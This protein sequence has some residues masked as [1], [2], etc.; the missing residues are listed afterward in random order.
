MHSVALTRP[1]LFGSLHLFRCFVLTFDVFLSFIMISH[2]AVL[3]SR[4][5]V[6]KVHRDFRPR[7]LSGVAPVS[8]FQ[9]F[10]KKKCP[11]ATYFPG[12]SRP[13]IFG[14][15]GLYR[16]VRDGNGCFP[17]P[18]RHRTNFLLLHS[19]K[20][21][22]SQCTDPYF[23]LRKEVIQPHLPIRLPCYDFTPV[24]SPAVD[25]SLLYRLGHRLR[26]LPAPMV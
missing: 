2:D 3:L 6:F 11:A 13:S 1:F 5:S 21:C 12:A 26:A 20:E 15:V 24:T 14:R 17:R 23:F 25:C 4:Y 9:P 8:C 18:H 22:D 16:R 7:R 10:W 19:F